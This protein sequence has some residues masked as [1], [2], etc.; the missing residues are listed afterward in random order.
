MHKDQLALTVLLAVLKAQQELTVLMEHR[1]LQESTELTV[2]MVLMETK[3]MS[4]RLAT[5]ETP[6]QPDRMVPT[7]SV[8][9]DRM[10]LTE[11]MEPTAP[12][13]RMVWMA[14]R[15]MLEIVE[16]RDSM[17]RTAWVACLLWP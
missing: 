6:G 17:A 5:K 14:N 16:I 1:V 8:P 11:S 15:E 4:V 12:T 2:K 3:A 9:T 10:V 13:D 7:A